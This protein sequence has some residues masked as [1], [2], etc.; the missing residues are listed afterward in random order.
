M[1]FKDTPFN[2]LLQNTFRRLLF[3]IGIA[4]KTAAVEDEPDVE[5]PVVET[6]VVP[7][8][9]KITITSNFYIIKFLDNK[10][11]VCYFQ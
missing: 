6:L 3:L 10:Y 5:M 7:I 1:N 8:N 2:S 4:G 9:E 11:H